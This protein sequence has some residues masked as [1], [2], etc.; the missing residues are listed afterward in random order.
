MDAT[1]PASAA[2]PAGRIARGLRNT[3]SA[4]ILP[5]LGGCLLLPLDSD[6]N[7][8]LG[9][10]AVERSPAHGARAAP[11]IQRGGRGE[12]FVDSLIAFRTWANASAVRFRLWNHGRVPITILGDGAGPAARAAGCLPGEGLYALQWRGS[13]GPEREVP[14]GSG[15]SHEYEATV[16]LPVPDE[17]A[18]AL[19]DLHCFDSRPVTP[20][21]VLRLAIEAG[22]DRYVYTFW[23][24]LVEGP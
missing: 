24:G 4:L 1:S 16:A 2:V 6:L 19:E 21:M 17:N 14:I 11:V 23:Y 8:R 13:P 12:L 22:S 20:R 5:L 9:L 7:P 15:A 18:T 10:E 3:A